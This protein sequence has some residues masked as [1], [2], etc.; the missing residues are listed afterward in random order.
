MQAR[1]KPHCWGFFRQ[2]PFIGSPLS[3]GRE[4]TK[5]A[6]MFSNLDARIVLTQK[7]QQLS[8]MLPKT[9]GTSSKLCTKKLRRLPE[10]FEKFLV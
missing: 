1:K 7:E 8:P 4:P 9:G 6:E 5:K 2:C 3:K 10:F